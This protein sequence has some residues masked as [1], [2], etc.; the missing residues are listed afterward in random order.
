M[1]RP[2]KAYTKLTAALRH[3]LGTKALEKL[4]EIATSA[5]SSGEPT[6]FK[7][8]HRL[9]LMIPSEDYTTYNFIPSSVKIGRRILKK[10]FESDLKN[11]QSLMGAM[12]GAHFGLVFEPYAH[13][14]LA[15]GGTFTIRNLK[16]DVIEDFKLEP[17]TTAEIDN[18]QLKYLELKDNKY[19][20]P[21]DPTFAVIDSWSKRDMCQMTVGFHHA[22]KSTAKQFKALQGKGPTRIIFVVP[23]PKEAAFTVQPLVLATGKNPVWAGAPKGGWNNIDQFVLGL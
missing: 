23:K 9:L 4:T 3:D 15:S 8:S 22:I 5:D 16:D 11:A 2:S 19:Y 1:F 6:R 14:V 17:L 10:T 7:M 20:V 13:F 18:S 21:T 12:S